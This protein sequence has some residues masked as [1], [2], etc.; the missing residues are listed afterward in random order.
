MRELA[1]H[2]LLK[3]ETFVDEFQKNVTILKRLYPDS[4]LFHQ[5]NEED[6]H[7]FLLN[8]CKKKKGAVVS[9]CMGETEYS[10]A[11][12]MKAG[13]LDLTLSLESTRETKAA[14]W[15]TAVTGAL[16]GCYMKIFR[17]RPMIQLGGQEMQ[18]NMVPPIVLPLFLCL[19]LHG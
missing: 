10:V 7:R 6:V 3:G 18:Y 12:E 8:A 17:T 9:A 5:E 15:K 4:P 2:R 19:N 1:L 11:F 16:G 13:A 14:E